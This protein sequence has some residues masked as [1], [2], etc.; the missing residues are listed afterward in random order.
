M[1]SS[2]ATPKAAYSMA[3]ISSA[4]FGPCNC[5]VSADT[6]ASAAILASLARAYPCAANSF[7]AVDTIRVLVD[8]A[9]CLRNSDR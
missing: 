3:A 2:S 9:C 1:L 8:C 4:A 7:A 5:T 6:P